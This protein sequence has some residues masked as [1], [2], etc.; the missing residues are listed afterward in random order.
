MRSC[1]AAGVERHAGDHRQTGFAG[2][3]HGQFGFGQIGHGFDHDAIGAGVGQGLGLFGKSGLQFV[4]A[5]LAHQQH[6][7][8][9]PDRG[10]HLGLA[11]GGL[12]GDFH[13]D[14]IDLGNLVGQSM[15]AENEA[16]RAEGV[17]QN[18]LAAGLDVGPGD[19]LDLFRLDQVPGIGT[20]SHGHSAELQLGAPGAVGNHGPRIPRTVGITA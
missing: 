11:T 2:G 4:R 18:H 1:F 13:A 8:A 12:F 15:P 3:G 16:I 17:G 6:H 14:A 19:F 9:G 7:A 10:E 5:D 20:R